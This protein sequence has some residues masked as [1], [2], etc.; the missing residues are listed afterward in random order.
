MADYVAVTATQGNLVGLYPVCESL[1]YRRV[2]VPKLHSA[3]GILEVVLP[4]AHQQESIR[5]A[6]VA[7]SISTSKERN[8]HAEKNLAPTN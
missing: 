4:H 1:M 7:A 6:E 8:C 2:S 5:D 3:I